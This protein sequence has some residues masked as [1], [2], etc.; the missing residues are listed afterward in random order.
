MLTKSL[1]Y[2]LSSEISHGL[3]SARHYYGS[4]DRGVYFVF[5]KDEMVKN[6]LKEDFR[7]DPLGTPRYSLYIVGYSKKPKATRIANLV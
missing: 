3:F 5:F 2:L 7:I 4:G 6:N 1:M